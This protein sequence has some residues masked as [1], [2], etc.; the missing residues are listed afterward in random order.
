MYN[1]WKKCKRNL[2]CE[3]ES[4]LK[5]LENKLLN[6]D[7]NKSKKIKEKNKE[8]KNLSPEEKIDKLLE[9]M[10]ER[11]SLISYREK[12]NLKFSDDTYVYGFWNKCKNKKKCDKKPYSKLLENKL[13]KENYEQYKITYKDKPKQISPKNKVN[14]LL[15]IMEERNT[16]ILQKENLKFS[17]KENNVADV[18][19]RDVGH[20]TKQDLNQLTND[21]KSNGFNVKVYNA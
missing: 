3:K 10:E 2:K 8:K 5:L 4:Y 16:L 14:E 17:P 20:G 21:L 13:L 11:D 12:E 7:Y 1:F 15:K 18:L 19:I 6:N 9:I